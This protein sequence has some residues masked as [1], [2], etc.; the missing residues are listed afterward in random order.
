MKTSK[1]GLNL[2]K[3]HEGFRNHPYKC[4]AG[5]WTIGYGFTFYPCGTKVT[6]DDE[7]ITKSD[8]DNML[9]QL[10]ETFE[11][12]VNNNVDTT[13]N[14]NQFDALVSFTFNLG[15]A[16]L[17][18]S[19]LLKK[20]NQDSCDPSIEGEFKKWVYSNGEKLSGL[21]RRRNQEAWLYNK[22]N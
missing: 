16:N 1:E 15:E 7:P 3:K 11:D 8:A 4:P 18:S 6:M 21:K 14:Q 19:T 22:Q 13:L 20:V 5:I 2:I 17:K 12:A 9:V 10:V